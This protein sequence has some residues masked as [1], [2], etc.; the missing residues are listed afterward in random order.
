MGRA[1]SLCGGF[2]PQWEQDWKTILPPPK[3]KVAR[4]G[5]ANFFGRYQGKDTPISNFADIIEFCDVYEKPTHSKTRLHQ[6]GSLSLLAEKAQTTD[7]T[8]L[9]LEY[10]SWPADRRKKIYEWHRRAWNVGAAGEP[11]GSFVAL[12]PSSSREMRIPLFRS[13]C[14]V[15]DDTKPLML[16]YCE[17]LPLRHEF[18]DFSEN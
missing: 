11:D 2:V 3:S 16:I 15:V 9:Q 12:Y 4:P 13:A 8:I 10:E 7:A 14:R 17:T 18:S 6:V 1:L 5:I